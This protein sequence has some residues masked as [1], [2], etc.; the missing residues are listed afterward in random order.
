MQEIKIRMKKLSDFK[1]EK[2]IEVAAD[3]LEVCLDILADKKNM[4]QKN[5]KQPIKMFSSFMKNSPEN[6]KKIFAILSEI[7]PAEYDCDGAE[8]MTNMLLLA[9]DPIMLG[10]FLSPGQSA[11][12]ENSGSGSENTTVPEM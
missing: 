5:E 12:G 10:L 9:N 1:G 3:V 8:A 6:M 4:E 2:G 11:E 7:D